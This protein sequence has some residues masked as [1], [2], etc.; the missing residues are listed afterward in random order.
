MP[1][2]DDL[3]RLCA[4]AALLSVAGCADAFTRAD[5]LWP[6]SGDAVAANKALQ[7]IDPWPSRSRNAAF[8][9]NGARI[10][11]AIRAYKMGKTA[12]APPAPVLVTR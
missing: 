10:G 4:F 11:E 3:L 2:G 9:A 12:D 6:Y 1:R 5:D 7:T 8:P